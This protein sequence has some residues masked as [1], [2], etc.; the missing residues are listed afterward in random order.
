MSETPETYTAETEAQQNGKA[1]APSELKLPEGT[2]RLPEGMVARITRL[3]RENQQVQDALY[4][5]LEGRG[6]TGPYT[7]V[8][9]VMLLVRPQPAEGGGG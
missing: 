8:V 3:L 6:D 5:Y 2:V 7:F 4:S 9:P 1:P